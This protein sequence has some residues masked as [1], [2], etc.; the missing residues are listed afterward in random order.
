MFRG[1]NALASANQIG[2]RLQAALEVL[3]RDE[4]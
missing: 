4:G 1:K 2:D 3:G